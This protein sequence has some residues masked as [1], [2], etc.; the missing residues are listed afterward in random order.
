M[1]SEVRLPVEL[2]AL[3]EIRWRASRHCAECSPQSFQ[4]TLS[5]LKQALDWLEQLEQEA[6]A[7]RRYDLL[8]PPNVH[9][10]GE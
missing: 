2:A 4:A 5:E 1:R 6:A 10:R 9:D 3:R 7:G 8:P